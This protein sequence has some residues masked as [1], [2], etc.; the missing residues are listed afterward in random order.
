MKNLLLLILLAGALQVTAQQDP[1]YAQYINN[2]LAINPAFAGSN[3][4]FNAGL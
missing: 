2:P 1:I 4:M 3:N